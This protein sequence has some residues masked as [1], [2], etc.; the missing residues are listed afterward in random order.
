MNEMFFSMEEVLK[1]SQMMRDALGGSVLNLRELHWVINVGVL[2]LEFLDSNSLIP[3]L[4]SWKKASEKT[5]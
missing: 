4:L 1:Q 3:N 5:Y 2:A